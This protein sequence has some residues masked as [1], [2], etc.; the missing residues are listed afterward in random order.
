M[1]SVVELGRCGRSVLLVAF[2]VY[3]ATLGYLVL[4]P[5]AGTADSV[6]VEV[7]RRLHPVAGET[8]SVRN[9]EFAANVVLFVPLTLLG[10]TLWARVKIGTWLAIA[11]AV[12]CAIESAQNVFLPQRYA[13]ASD[14][15]A[16]TL[17]GGV[18][19]VLCAVVAAVV[20]RL[21]RRPGPLGPSSTG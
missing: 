15:I 8:V 1:T 12:T 17:G 2:V 4:W 7:N 13:M 21:R 16:N 19:L 14:L 9:V 11:V 10:R 18:G 3:L 6:V 5:T 20:S